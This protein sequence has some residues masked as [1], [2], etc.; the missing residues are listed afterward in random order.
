MPEDQTKI[1]KLIGRFNYILRFNSDDSIYLTFN[2]QDYESI[3]NILER[4]SAV[5]GLNESIRKMFHPQSMKNR[6]M[7]ELYTADEDCELYHINDCTV[8]I[9]TNYP[10]NKNLAGIQIINLNKDKREKA[11]ET[12][13][14]ILA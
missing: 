13:E 1:E 9:F 7:I 12:L 4:E 5:Q 2:K 14:R 6:E 11:L 8:Q 10:L 3:N